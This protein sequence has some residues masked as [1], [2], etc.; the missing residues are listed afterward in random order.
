[1]SVNIYLRE[2]LAPI[3]KK[4]ISIA[5]SIEDKKINNAMKAFGYG[6]SPGNIVALFDNT[7]FGSGKDGLLFTGEQVI[8]RATFSDPVQIAYRDLASINHVQIASKANK[9]KLSTP[10]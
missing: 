9:I 1:M 2:N 7:I 8:Y 3:S 10:S 4:N 6:G 5:P